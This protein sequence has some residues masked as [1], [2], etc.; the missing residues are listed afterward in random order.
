MP[1]I[2]SYMCPDCAY[3]MEV[4]LRADEWE[5]PAPA[6]PRCAADPMGQE[7]KPPA[8]TGSNIARASAMAE[9]IAAEDYGASIH[10]PSRSGP[11]VQYRDSSAANASAWHAGGA[12]LSQAVALG[13]E[14]RLRYGSGLDVLQA[15]LKSGAQP[16]LIEMSK[17]RSMRVW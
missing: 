16:D 11:R 13:R 8:I 6:C 2:R 15:N 14:T 5:A 9:K 7:F 17:R 12:E 1:I 3:A 4:T 10:S